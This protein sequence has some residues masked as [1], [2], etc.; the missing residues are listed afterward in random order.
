MSDAPS[1]SILAGQLQYLFEDEPGLR[2]ASV[3]A[4]T[5]RLNHDDRF[6]RARAQNPMAT[7]DEVR[8]A[9]DG[10]QDRITAD[11]VRAALAQLGTD[12]GS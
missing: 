11:D 4:L 10:F 1:V 8:A 2:R 3:D 5:E 9:I 6:A 7:D 12:E